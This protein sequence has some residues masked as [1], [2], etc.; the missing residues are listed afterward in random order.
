MHN[1]HGVSVQYEI[2]TRESSV[3]IFF[4]PEY[5][6]VKNKKN[7]EN[8]RRKF[9]FFNNIISKCQAKHTRIPTLQ[10]F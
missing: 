9:F 6:S 5:N 8:S 7:I 1:N 4:L 10:N 3:I 2:S